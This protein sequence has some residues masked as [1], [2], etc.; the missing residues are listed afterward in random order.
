V[1]NT[2]T[3]NGKRAPQ[4]GTR[5]QGKI[6]GDGEQLPESYRANREKATRPRD[7]AS[8]TSGMPPNAGRPIIPH[9]LTFRGMT[10]TLSKAYRMSDEAIRHSVDNAHMMLNDPVIAG[11]MFARQMMTSLL[12]W[13]VEPEDDK[14]PQ[15]KAIATDITKI[16]QRIPRFTE[17]RRNL[18]EAVWYGRHMIQNHWGHHFG[19][20]GRRRT[21]VKA[22]TPVSGDK[23]V[24]RYDDGSGKFNPDQIGVKISPALG[25]YDMIAGDRRYEPTG[26]GL[27]YFF[28]DWER[29]RCTLHRHLIR[30]GE[31]EDPLS[32]AQIHGVGIRNFLY[33]TWY[34][35]QETL[36]QLMEV[37]ERTGMGFT[38]YYYPSGNPAARDEVEKI[39]VEQAHTNVILMPFEAEN[40]DS[41]RI[42]QI[43]ANTAGLEVL[44]GLIED[45]FGDQ[46]TRFI[47]GQTLST[48]ADA[49]GLGSGV[50]DLHQDSL[51]QIV[52][53]DSVNLEET[54]TRDLI[55]PIVQ[56]NYPK[57]R[58]ADFFFRIHTE[59]SVPAQELDA[60]MKAWQM[61]AKIKESDVLD[62]IGISAP[63]PDEK[64]LENP[65]VAQAQQ[66]QEPGGL[67]D[68]GGMVGGEELPPGGEEMAGLPEDGDDD[69]LGGGFGGPDDGEP[70]GDPEGPPIE[71]AEDGED[72]T[73][74]EAVD[75][76]FGPIMNRKNGQPIR[77]GQG[78]LF[79]DMKPKG[80]KKPPK[81]QSTIDWDELLHPRGDDGK[82]AT[83]AGGGGADPEPDPID[84][85]DPIDE[86]AAE[87]SIRATEFQEDVKA[88]ADDEPEHFDW[89]AIENEDW[90]RWADTMDPLDA[91]DVLL[92]SYVVDGP[93][94][95]AGPEEDPE[96]EEPEEIPEVPADP[97]EEPEPFEDEPEPEPEPEPEDP[98]DPEEEP[99]VIGEGDPDPEPD[100]EPAPDEI[101]E[102]AAGTLDEDEDDFALEDPREAADR[103]ARKLDDD[104]AWARKSAIPNRGEDL[105]GS[106]RHRANAWQGLHH[107]ELEGNAEEMVTRDNLL[108][109]EPCNLMAIAD[110]TGNFLTAMSMHLMIKAFPAKPGYGRKKSA[111]DEEKAKENRKDFVETF[112]TLIDKAEDLAANESD[113]KAAMD[114]FREAV[115]QE[116]DRLRSGGY[117]NRFNDTANAIIVM[118]KATGW[119]GKVTKAL[120]Q[121][122]EL[123][124]K[125]VA[126]PDLLSDLSEDRTEAAA[127][128]MEIT[129]EKA[130][131]VIEGHSINK[132][133]G[134]ASKRTASGNPVFR[135]AELYVKR[136]TN[137]KGGRPLGISATA[138]GEE[139][140]NQSLD[141]MEFDM[142]LRGIQF[143]NGLTEDERA[144]HGPRC[145]AALMD[146]ADVLGI[147]DADISLDGKLGLRIAANGKSGAMAHYE[148]DRQCINMTRKNGVG[149]LAHEWGHFFDHHLTSYTS[150]GSEFSGNALPGVG[151][152]M[153]GVTSAMRESGY[154]ERLSGVLRKMVA[155][156]YFSHKK[157][158][159]YWNSGREKFARCFEMHVQHKL[160]VEDRE[161]TY[162]SSNSG[163]DLWPTKEEQAAMAPHFDKL[164]STW[165][166]RQR[167]KQPEKNA[168]DGTPEKYRAHSIRSAAA[169]VADAAA[170]TKREPSN[171]QITSGNYPKGKFHLH[172]LH[173]AIET[174]R[175]AKRKSKPGAKKQWENILGDHYGYILR[176]TGRDGDHVDVFIGNKPHLETVYIIDQCT[177]GGRFDEHKVMWGFDTQRA[178]RKAYLA[179]YD[180]DWT[181]GPITAMTVPQ[182]KAWLQLGDTTKPIAK[183]ASKYRKEHGLVQQWERGDG[184][185][186]AGGEENHFAG[187]EQENHFTAAAKS[188]DGSLPVQY[189]DANPMTSAMEPPKP[190][191]GAVGAAAGDPGKNPGET[192]VKDGKTYVLNDNH[193]WESSWEPKELG[194]KDSP[195]VGA[196]DAGGDT[197]TALESGKFKPSNEFE[198]ILQTAHGAGLVKNA[199]HV[200]Y[201]TNNAKEPKELQ[202]AIEMLK[203]V[204]GAKKKK[205]KKDPK[206]KPKEPGTWPP[207]PL[208]PKATPDAT[209]TTPK[210]GPPPIPKGNGSPQTAPTQNPTQNAP[211][212]SPPAAAPQKPAAKPKNPPQNPAQPPTGNANA[213]A[214]ETKLISDV[215]AKLG[216]RGGDIQDPRKAANFVHLQ[217]RNLGYNPQGPT[218]HDQSADAA[219]WLGQ[220]FDHLDK[221]TAYATSLGFKSSAKNAV[222][223]ATRAAE[224]LNNAATKSG[225]QSDSTDPFTR[226]LGAINHLEG[227]KTARE[228][229][230]M[231]S[232]LAGSS[233]M[234]IIGAVAKISAAGLFGQ[235]FADGMGHLAGYMTGQQS[236]KDNGE[237]VIRYEVIG[238]TA[239]PMAY[240]KAARYA[241]RYARGRQA[242][243]DR[244]RALA[245][246]AARHAD[247][248]VGVANATSRSGGAVG[249]NAI[250]PK[251]VAE[252]IGKPN[253]ALTILDFGA[254]KKAVQAQGLKSQGYNVTAYEFG[255]NADPALHHPQALDS[256]YDIVY[257]SNVLNVQATGQDLQT[258]VKEIWES[259]KPGGVFVGNVPSSP[260]KGA[261]DGKD[262]TGGTQM[263]QA[264]LE[265]LFEQ[266]TIAT[267]GN[268]SPIFV[269]RKA[270]QSPQQNARQYA[271]QLGMFGEDWDE[272]KHP[273]EADGKFGEKNGGKKEQQ[274][275]LWRGLDS[276]LPGQMD[277]LDED[278]DLAKDTRDTKPKKKPKVTPQ[279]N[280]GIG[281]GV[282]EAK[283]YY[284][285]DQATK[286]A[287]D[288]ALEVYFEPHGNGGAGSVQIRDI[289]TGFKLETSAGKHPTIDSA[290]KWIEGQGIPLVDDKPPEDPTPAVED[291]D[292]DDDRLIVDE[293]LSPGYDATAP[294]SEESTA[295]IGKR[296]HDETIELW[297]NME[298]GSSAP[299]WVKKALAEES[300][301]GAEWKGKADK[302][303]VNSVLKKIK[304]YEADY[305]AIEEQMEDI[306]NSYKSRL[307]DEDRFNGPESLKPGPKRK[308]ESLSKKQD[309]LRDSI[310]AK[311]AGANG[312]TREAIY[313]H[314]TKTM[315]PEDHTYFFEGNDLEEFGLTDDGDALRP[316]EPEELEEQ[317]VAGP[318]EIDDPRL[319]GHHHSLME[320]HPDLTAFEA[321]LVWQDAEE[322]YENQDERE[323]RSILE[324]E[325]EWV[326]KHTEDR[327]KELYTGD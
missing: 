133:F 16:L 231:R 217:A 143:G 320:R 256:A 319:N 160:G 13:S 302:R 194:P 171:E 122:T 170:I 78:M 210:K 155:E 169:L 115:G 120:D 271:K 86:P 67:P 298:D 325:D 76:I 300:P 108:K 193:R 208:Q 105:L 47:L 206:P 23:I 118:Q 270:R 121:F 140:A 226:T 127:Q 102:E 257:A 307:P 245:Y 214:I 232:Q 1:A 219:A 43:P 318:R 21:I 175:G 241:T 6:Y 237:D 70:E 269:A 322:E 310:I 227:Q 138:E 323:Q 44:H 178:A 54:I 258:T 75:R 94:D 150:Y 4:G 235:D 90:E 26:D 264:V 230:T 36:A 291:E 168:K 238:E 99:E 157:A 248:S 111:V 277:F 283:S 261:F 314:E 31:F 279:V 131:L 205:P 128:L 324:I 204:F 64:A 218:K 74:D 72:G 224:F 163:H 250:V 244:V 213:I 303:A 249:G 19:Y 116:I 288:E 141:I 176:T 159:E 110:D 53:Y 274:G 10:T 158:Q 201:L 215:S 309:N 93:E 285:S 293:T 316:E 139:R 100:P 50:A 18:L 96:L 233:W 299:A 173:F 186:F 222:H 195:N 89:A 42:E 203:S 28:E 297:R 187:T 185:H 278:P 92:A 24:F 202:A 35:K 129:N 182:F 259:V 3:I 190:P 9:V 253:K 59:A 295:A 34:Q 14:D 184:N 164:F 308:Y 125:H 109:N 126:D 211:I 5:Y 236:A 188:A 51:F 183:Q 306:E 282:M 191:G 61:G 156:K 166:D 255:G 275:V 280:E 167:E 197:L 146:L 162:L 8:G 66:Q 317:E 221:T 266:V 189:A 290:R 15:L 103:K 268:T 313:E 327:R 312:A 220:Q 152:A 242:F 79:D 234:D 225:Y 207:E 198:K 27:C 132:A 239:D 87:L 177:A 124:S 39:A 243:R 200:N 262:A 284:P 58:T 229:M 98:A 251:F 145:A 179:N 25:K 85:T 62:R 41:Y 7:P 17:Y 292:E 101:D 11:P 106:A 83:G 63:T 147:D 272:E 97:E 315:S 154:Q 196:Q 82:F 40:P 95:P 80:P 252:A 117:K 286:I 165:K 73:A 144:H 142:K 81:K 148:P 192:M 301:A 149:S 49:T 137:R 46:I 37:V 263:V 287:E 228:R 181:C 172:G 311:M 281:R 305:D 32:G 107:A 265:S 91:I 2:T 57:Y 77:H 223:K 273:R 180:K 119:R 45:H 209:N 216:L 134:Q 246:K 289:D 135:P 12:N 52:K 84:E 69:P 304:T 20:D 294:D 296:S 30:D 240:E 136:P 321:I 123:A 247:D 65:Q 33:W 260:R 88:L 326:R 153:N 113:P 68:M 151:E 114:S 112:Q 60:I 71:F 254:G 199:G 38:V 130:R 212:V 48:K 22:W 267:G 104:Y 55:R 29:S 174:P 276:D 161:N 56:F